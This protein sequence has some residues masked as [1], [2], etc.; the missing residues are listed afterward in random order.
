MLRKILVSIIAT[1]PYFA[2]VAQTEPPAEERKSTTTIS[3]SA[4]VYYKYSFNKT[5]AT[6]LT[7]F[8]QTHNS[9]AL[10]M[11]SVKL[12]HKTNKVSM[13]ADLGF[14]Q[15]AADFSYNDEGIVAAIKQ[16]YVSYAPVDWLKFTMGSW[17]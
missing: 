16:L 15:R 1:A 4:D 7:S 13:V 10:G 3:G 11:A 6:E 17:A 8:T 12:E 5:K 9:F 2:A 14:G